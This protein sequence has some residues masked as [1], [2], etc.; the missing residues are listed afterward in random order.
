MLLVYA[1]LPARRVGAFSN[2]LKLNRSIILTIFVKHKLIAHKNNSKNINELIV[3]KIRGHINI[4][5]DLTQVVGDKYYE[6]SKLPTTF[7]IGNVLQVVTDRKLA[8]DSGDYN[9]ETG[10]YY[11][12]ILG[13][14]GVVDY[15]VS[16][17]VSQSDYYPFGMMLPGR[18]SSEED[19]R[20]GFNG[21][22]MD[23][24]I[25]GE[26]NS[27]DFGARLYNP[28]VGRWL[29]G[30]PHEHNYPGLSTFVFAFNSPMAFNDPNGK[31]G[32]LTIDSENHT[33]TLQTTVHLYGAE[34]ADQG[35][36][37]AEQF[38]KGMD[39][40]PNVRKV[41]DPNDPEVVWTIKI[42]VEFVYND[43]IDAELDAMGVP[44]SK[45][46]HIETFEELAQNNDIGLNQGDNV[47]K[48]IAGGNPDTGNSSIGGNEAAGGW[49]FS[50]AIHEVFHMLGYDERYFSAGRGIS[51]GAYLGDV[52]SNDQEVNT[53]KDFHFVDLMIWTMDNFDVCTSNSSYVGTI[54]G[55]EEV[56]S[57]VDVT[58]GDGNVTT[59]E[60]RT[61]NEVIIQE[62]QIDNTEGGRKFN[63]S[64]DLNKSEQIVSE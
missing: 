59:W 63:T 62:L 40:L 45:P 49:S 2:N 50:T 25:S 51:I 1:R 8:I 16:D 14:D 56:I 7:G 54:K 48:G 43:C 53:I 5:T 55:S 42:D 41:Q 60:V 61:A 30:D 26:G 17:V 57:Y 19:Y 31:D 18:N 12:M 58:D 37:Y 39:G 6:L 46:I 23:D 22:E 47:Y 10:T 4:N 24:E 32:I 38:N 34:T 52:L 64:E 36:V 15:Y 28:R 35:Q 21:M 29:S 9:P 20:Y 27:Y 11:T 3:S 44:S 33:I 13:G